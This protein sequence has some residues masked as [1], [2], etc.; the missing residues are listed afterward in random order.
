MLSA[1]AKAG[2]RTI[3]IMGGEPT[4]H[5]DLVVFVTDAVQRG[6]A[7]N[8]SSNGSNLAV[9]HEIMKISEA[10]TAGISVN[11]RTT[12]EQVRGF[13]TEHHPVVKSV[14]SPAM[15]ANLIQSILSLEP[16]QYYVIY[17][18]ALDQDELS[19]AVPFP[20]F[21][22]ATERDYDR[23]QVGMVFCSG[24]LP[25][26]VNY[27]ELAK[28]RC[29]AGTTKLGIMPDGSVYPCNLFFSKREF[30]LGN[31]LA[32]PFERIWSHPRLAFFRA[33]PMNACPRTSC[34]LHAECHGGCPAHGLFLAGALAAP[35]PRCIP[36][37]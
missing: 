23:A 28:V 22:R 34:S 18:D 30:L 2:V 33:A 37:G 26:A 6:F 10:V 12:L 9:L 5:Q 36:G 17:R 35:D 14:Y 25:D 11:D 7:V 16:K 15:D 13:I 27:P 24:F 20:H 8:I 19:L 21:L 1:L 3:D 31:V 29:P 4:L 32:D